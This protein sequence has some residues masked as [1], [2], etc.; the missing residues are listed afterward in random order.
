MLSFGLP[1][2]MPTQLIQCRMFGSISVD[3]DF[4][5]AIP[6]SCLGKMRKCGPI[7]PEKQGNEY[8]ATGCAIYIFKMDRDEILHA[9][10]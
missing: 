5:V 7:V 10:P 6:R 8:P 1:G 9:F 4:L 2:E 3:Q